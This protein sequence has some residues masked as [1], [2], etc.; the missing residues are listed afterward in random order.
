MA[1]VT[2]LFTLQRKQATASGARVKAAAP[3]ATRISKGV[4]AYRTIREVAADLGVATHVLRFWESKFPQLKPL[5]KSGGRRYYKPEDVALLRHIQG[6]LYD[7]GY[8]IRGVQAYLST[9]KKRD[10]KTVLKEES[11]TMKQV[12]QE[13]GTIKKMLTDDGEE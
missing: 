2:D 4:S 10:L 7:Q 3:V 13:L 9:A 8:T 6:L 12:M 1:P 5:K 11:L